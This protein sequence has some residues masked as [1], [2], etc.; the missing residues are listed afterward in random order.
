M[1]DNVYSE[2]ELDVLVLIFTLPSFSS[3]TNVLKMPIHLRI[4]FITLFF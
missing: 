2:D 4:F 3:S 1:S